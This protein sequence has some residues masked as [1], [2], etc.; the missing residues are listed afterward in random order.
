MSDPKIEYYPKTNNIYIKG[1]GSADACYSVTPRDN[2][3]L[4]RLIN[5]ITYL[6]NKG[7]EEGMAG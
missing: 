4:V 1:V 7:D 5:L 3:D 2:K 6:I